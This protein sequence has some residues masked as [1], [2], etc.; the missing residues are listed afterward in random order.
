MAKPLVVTENSPRYNCCDHCYLQE[1]SEGTRYCR[2]HPNTHLVPCEH[3]FCEGR[4]QVC[5]TAS[6]TSQQ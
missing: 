4:L 1:D 3:T 2:E 5:P 6:S